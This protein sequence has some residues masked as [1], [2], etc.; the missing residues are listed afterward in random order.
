MCR[1]RWQALWPGCNG[2]AVGAS[3]KPSSSSACTSTMRSPVSAS[4][5]RTTS[6]W[7][8]LHASQKPPSPRA[9]TSTVRSPVRASSSHTTSIWPAPHA[10]RKPPSS[11]AC[12]STSRQVDRLQ[13]WQR[14][15][16]LWSDYNSSLHFRVVSIK[17]CTTR[18]QITLFCLWRLLHHPEPPP[19]QT[20]SQTSCPRHSRCL[21]QLLSSLSLLFL[22]LFSCWCSGGLSRWGQAGGL[23]SAHRN[24]SHKPPVTCIAPIP[25]DFWQSTSAR[26]T[27]LYV[28]GRMLQCT[29][30]LRR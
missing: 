28:R 18:A 26:S 7:P 5:S 23:R 3:R 16:R 25:P 21:F 17:T 1:C 15:I 30:L 20:L 27:P 19:F 6:R 10:S 9:C 13:P 24:V 8:C 14:R 4:S 29:R 2:G 12:T 11:R 22:F